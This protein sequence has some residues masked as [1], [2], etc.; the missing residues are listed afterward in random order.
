VKPAPAGH[1]GP[2]AVAA[3]D[4]G[5][6]STRLLV[7]AGDG[8]PVCRLMTVTRLGQGVDKSRRLD[9][10]AVGRTIEVLR[11]YRRVMDA[12]GVAAVR[13]TATSAAR[14]AANRAEFFAAATEAVGAAPELLS[15][16][17]EA[18]LSFTG[19]TADLDTNCRYIVA[20]IGGGS[21]EVAAGPGGGQPDVSVSLDVGCVRVTERWLP[22]DPPTA[23]ELRAARHGVTG[24]LQSA[25]PFTGDVLVGLA[26]TVSALAA[27]DQGVDDYDRDRLHHYRLTDHRVEVMLADLAS[28]PAAE[29]ARRPGIE[30]ARADVIVGGAVVLAVLMDVMGFRTCLTSESD[31]L[32]GLAMSLM[33]RS[34]RR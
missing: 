22:S 17:E 3:I 16:E 31:I 7:A 33:P 15:G 2:P 21:T 8:T 11:H 9:P 18:R 20:D 26:G 10:E 19:A 13:M 30:A 32:D 25:P 29:R 6:N 24:L 23:A 27:Y 34:T 28:V 14:D 5:T 12:N 4:C 1:H